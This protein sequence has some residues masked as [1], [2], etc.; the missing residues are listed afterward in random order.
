MIIIST[1]FILYFNYHCLEF[2]HDGVQHTCVQGAIQ[3]AQ[4][5]QTGRGAP[6]HLCSDPK[7]LESC[8]RMFELHLQML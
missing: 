6:G 8:Q 5:K 1:I 3:R 4:E 7:N 2:L